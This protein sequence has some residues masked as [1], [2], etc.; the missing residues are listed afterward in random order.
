MDMRQPIRKGSMFLM[1]WQ[2]GFGRWCADSIGGE[3]VWKGISRVCTQA[4]FTVKGSLI[5]ASRKHS[6]GYL[7]LLFMANITVNWNFKMFQHWRF[8]PA[9]WALPPLPGIRT[10]LL[11]FSY[12]VMKSIGESF[13]PIFNVKSMSHSL[14][15][16]QSTN[17][18]NYEH[19]ISLSRRT[20]KVKN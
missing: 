7:R 20:M 18:D 3:P 13:V 11:W 6:S 4:S 14:R 12:L 16:H 8:E 17:S 19:A 2:Q 9:T 1:N 5:L 15:V 10:V